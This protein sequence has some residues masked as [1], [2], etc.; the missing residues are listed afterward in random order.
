MHTFKEAVVSSRI[1]GARTNIEEALSEEKDIDPKMRDDWQKVNNYVKAMNSALAKLNKL[2]LSNRLIKNT[3]KVLLSGARGDHKTPGEFRDSQ[4]WI[5]G[6]SLADAIFVPPTHT[7]LPDLLADF[8][9]FLNNPEIKIP[10]LIRIAI[11]HYQFETIHPFLDGNGRIGRLLITLYLVSNGILEKPLLYLS[12]FFD[13]HKSLYYDNLTVVRE[14]NDLTQWLKF[15]L[16]G[17]MTTA[18]NAVNTLNQIIKLKS[19][20]ETNHILE[21][22][23][24]SKHARQM[25][26]LLFL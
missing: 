12:D 13:K 7:E 6:V 17:V 2:P 21:M 4:N 1:E 19:D 26:W 15:F 23:R 5:G 14:K 8:E 3:H 22:G 16:V 25:I 24:R 9:K 20:T 11:A 18:E 10:H